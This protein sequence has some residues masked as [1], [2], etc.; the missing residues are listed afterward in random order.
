MKSI[1]VA[2][3]AMFL[4]FA[5][6]TCFSPARADYVYNV[7]YA[8]AGGTVNGDIVLNCNSCNVTSTDLV[9]WSFS[10][11]GSFSL[12]SSA[13]TATATFSGVDLS[14]TP[15]NITFN[16]T[17]SAYSV[18]GGTSALSIPSASLFFGDPAVLYAG[19]CGNSGGSGEYG[20]CQ[21][22]I[23]YPATTANSLTIAVAAIPEPSTWAMM[24][25]GFCG[26]GFMAYRRKTTPSLM[27]AHGR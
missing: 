16:P 19:G 12:S 22:G 18:F 26:V 14:A 11:T 17:T 15:S 2:R 1:S 9:S 24:I 8:L 3:L 25:L 20:G 27:N 6:L 4:L 21:D 13:P 5:S 7:S 23:L 10:E